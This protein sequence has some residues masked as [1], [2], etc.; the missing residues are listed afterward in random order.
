MTRGNRNKCYYCGQPE[1]CTKDH[2]IAKSKKGFL[3]VWACRICQTSKGDMMPLLWLDYLK[4]HRLIN[5]ETMDRVETA[6]MSLWEKVINKKIPAAR[7]LEKIMADE[8]N[9]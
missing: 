2:F 5:K 1:V 3:T 9:K 6:V 7:S 4:S 8:L